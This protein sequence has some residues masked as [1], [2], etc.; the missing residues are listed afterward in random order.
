MAVTVTDID[1][2]DVTGYPGKVQTN[3]LT[4][5]T[6]TIETGQSGGQTNGDR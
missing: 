5:G 3:T 2:L 6:M 4:I 1:D